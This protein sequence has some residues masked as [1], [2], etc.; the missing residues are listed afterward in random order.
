MDVEVDT[1]TQMV[2][3]LLDLSRVESREA[4][5]DLAPTPVSDLMVTPVDRLRPQAERAGLDLS[6]S[7]PANLPLVS[8]DAERIRIVLTNLIHNA[9]KF[10]PPGGKILVQAELSEGEVIIS[11]ADTGVGIPAGDL[12]RIFE[13]FYKADRAR[14]G[15]G[16]G[17]GLA[18]AKHTIQGHGGRI[19][20]ESTEGRGS[21]FH[22][23][24]PIVEG[25]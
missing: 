14:S 24:L 18:I 6:I 8:A 10:T 5:L 9:V 1:L 3:E 23:S 21:T 25:A 2:Q 11:V 12:D 4:P 7:L 17:L 13:R 19:W 16:T 15:G 22:F 20:A